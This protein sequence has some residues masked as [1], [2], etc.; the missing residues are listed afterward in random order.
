MR[1]I[2]L[3]SFIV[4]PLVA[5]AQSS[6]SVPAY[7]AEWN[8]ADSLVAEGLPK[9]A[10]AVVDQIYTRAKATRNYPQVAKAALHRMAYRTAA[11]EANYMLQIRSLRKDV[12]DTPEPAR[13]VLQS[14]L[15]EIYWRYYQQNRYK[16][17][18]RTAVSR[19]PVDGSAVDPADKVA[20]D[21]PAAWDAR[22]L[23]AEIAAAYEES[24]K[25]ADLLQNTTLTAYD[26]ILDRG[27]A[28]ARLLRP[29]LYDVLAH[30]AISYFQNTETDLLKPV[31]RF[32]LDQPAYLTGPEAFVAL[33]LT[34]QDSLS[35]RFHAL[36]IYQQLIRQH[37]TDANALALADADNLRLKFVHQYS[38][39]PNKDSL[40]RQTLESQITRHKSRAPAEADYIFSLSQHLAEQ[41]RQ[42]RPLVSNAHK[43]DR[44]QAAD[45]ARDL[46]SRF[47]AT[48]VGRNANQLID[49][50]TAQ[51]LTPG[52][53]EVTEPNKPFRARVTYQ[54]V[55][56]VFYRIYRI[57]LDAS[58]NEYGTIVY[59]EG[60][61]QQAALRKLLAYPQVAQ[62]KTTLPDDGD[63]QPHIVE[64]PLPALPL[65]HYAL[66][67]GTNEPF[68]ENSRQITL[69]PFTVSQLGYM[70]Q[71]TANER[72][73]TIYVTDRQTGQPLASVQVLLRTKLR[74]SSTSVPESELIGQTDANGRINISQTRFPE[75]SE[76]WFQFTGGRDVLETQSD[77]YYRPYNNSYQSGTDEQPTALFFT[78]R[79]IYRP[80]QTIYFKG[81]LYQG[82]SNNFNVV[83][84]KETTV[85]LRDVNQEE[86]GK[87]KLTTNEF[88]TFTGTFIATTGRLTGRMTI[89]CAFGETTIRVEEYKRPTF[90]VAIDP[91]KKAFKLDQ[92]VTLSALAKTLAG[93]IVDGAQVRYRV[94]RTYYRPYWSYW[95]RQSQDSPT[96]E[97]ASGEAITDD[98]GVVRISF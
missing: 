51:S 70:T 17:Y 3:L 68:T 88:G 82:K 50:L 96:A 78:D 20:P 84:G 71:K 45:L 67:L 2:V 73:Q 18:Q 26:V 33:P 31:F 85:S 65:G 6:S 59:G 23:F 93:A 62:G 8:R 49:Q 16:F 56:T 41:G 92:T 76:Y 1:T 10:L 95:H 13:S 48:L 12:T 91:V 77:Y 47:P 97:I 22:R 37:L 11:D 27:E 44:K 42:Y 32:E 81:L 90:A 74:N 55:P 79:A 24:L 29:T 21:D 15:A 35:N 9:S 58:R 60:K 57:P 54:N 5:Q 40:Y 34:T 30:R 19:T 4:A 66:L 7:Q 83:T 53:E 80:G 39:V 87:L 52:L 69:T 89:T 63:L 72:S 43:S 61:Q 25:K 75:Q 36:R 46:V 38:V 94:T 14:V 64:M 86:V 28:E 98:K